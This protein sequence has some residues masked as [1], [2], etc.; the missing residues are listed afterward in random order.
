MGMTFPPNFS[1]MTESSCRQLSRHHGSPSG[2]RSADLRT[3]DTC[4]NYSMVDIS[5]AT[6]KANSEIDK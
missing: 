1:L 3:L 5:A 2:L 4:E 6:K